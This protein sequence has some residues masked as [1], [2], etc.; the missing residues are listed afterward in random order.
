MPLAI[1][2]PQ[3]RFDGIGSR[4]LLSWDEGIKMALVLRPLKIG[5][6]LF[7]HGHGVVICLCNSIKCLSIL[8]NHK[9]RFI[10]CTR[11]YTDL[12]NHVNY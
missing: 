2:K 10:R 11:R 5:E 4:Q 6:V 8:D 7:G 12:E 9:I 1:T 3:K